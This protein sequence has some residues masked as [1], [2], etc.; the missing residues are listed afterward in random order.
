[1]GDR[2]QATCDI[3]VLGIT[4][5]DP[6]KKTGIPGLRDQ[7]PR[8]FFLPGGQF[9]FQGGRVEVS[10]PGQ[11]FLQGAGRGTRQGIREM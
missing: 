1:M 7:D 6:E 9:F 3:R 2:R 8:Q 5:R 4:V 10:G 11:F